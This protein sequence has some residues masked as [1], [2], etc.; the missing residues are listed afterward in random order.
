MYLFTEHAFINRGVYRGPYLPIYGAG[1][2]LLC[3]LLRGFRKKPM[4]VFFLSMLICSAL[5]YFT[6]GSWSGS[7][8]SGGGIMAGTLL[9]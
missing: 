7:G 2:L 6:S 1:G 4:R 9:T 5:E 8:A 3:F